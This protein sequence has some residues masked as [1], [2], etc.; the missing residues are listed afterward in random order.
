MVLGTDEG[1]W[2]K[3]RAEAELRNVLAR[4]DAGIWRP[5]DHRAE[6][7][8]SPLAPRF[9]VFASEWFNARVPELAPK[10][11]IDYRWRLSNHLLP[12]F[13]AKR[14][15]EIDAHLVDQFRSFKLREAEDI[16]RAVAAGADLRDEDGRR[17]RPLGPSSINKLLSLLAAILDT[18][19]DYGYLDRNPARGRQ[20]RVK[21]RTRPA[22]F[23]EADELVCVLDAAAGLDEHARGGSSP[24]RDQIEALLA[25]GLPL[26]GIAGRLGLTPQTVAYHAGR[27][28]RGDRVRRRG[29]TIDRHA[30][31]TTLGCAGLRA[32]ELCT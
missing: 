1:G 8:E 30:I 29:A 28:H 25:E 6:A 3:K 13:H 10:T 22:S 19:V 24:R 31:M 14:V 17:L 7:K 23:L 21:D 32:H 26:A 18:A 27:I 15:D 5:P 2:T 16:R 11:H 9:H 12:F 20:R 4:I